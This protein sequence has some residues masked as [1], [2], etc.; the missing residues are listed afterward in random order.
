MSLDSRAEATAA[1]GA[2][3]V[4][5]RVAGECAARGCVGTGDVVVVRC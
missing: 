3:D 2:K 4:V 1:K 5:F